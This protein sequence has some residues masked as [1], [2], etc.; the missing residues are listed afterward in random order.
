MCVVLSSWVWTEAGSQPHVEDALSIGGF[1]YPVTTLAFSTSIHPS[2]QHLCQKSL[3]VWLELGGNIWVPMNVVALHW[4]QL[5]L[6]CL[7]MG[8]SAEHLNAEATL[9]VINKGLNWK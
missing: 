9:L 1:G 2:I 4:A 5:S 6:G 8:S 3:V 7:W